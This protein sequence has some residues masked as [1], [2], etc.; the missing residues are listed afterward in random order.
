[1]F[2]SHIGSSHSPN[3]NKIMNRFESVSAALLEGEAVVLKHDGVKIYNGHEKVCRSIPLQAEKYRNYYLQTNFED[4]E[5]T[6]TTHR[7]FWGKQGDFSRGS[8]VIQLRLKLIRSLDEEIG[9]SM[10]FGK[11]KRLII[12]LND[13]SGDKLPG[14]MDHT[15]F[16]F[17]KLSAPNGIT[18]NFTQALN[19]TLMARVFDID[20][21]SP[22]RV[23]IKQRS[24][25]V[26]IE[27]SMQEKQKQTNE[28][29]SVAFQDLSKL[30]VMAKD[31]VSV[32]KAISQKIRDRQ[33]DASE[34]ET[35]K[36]KTLLMSLGIDDP[37]TKDNF[38]NNAEY[39]RSLGNE[40]CQS[41]LD[42]L[43]VSNS[44][45]PLIL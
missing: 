17:I 35:Q 12:R 26:G 9:S 38:T 34:D 21:S 8:N 33:S 14:P 31:M 7:I 23:A 1:L 13:V 22:K 4:G 39:L 30:I 16:T 32:S 41:L 19:E 15:N 3:Q 24:G 36:F 42:Q 45:K 27:K 6:L 43:T 11:K 20:E 44:N 40:I 5:A 28:N 18:A 2:L 37:V 25:I 10:F 29:I